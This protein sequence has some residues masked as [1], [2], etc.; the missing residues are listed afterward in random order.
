MNNKKKIMNVY[1]GERDG[2]GHLDRREQKILNYYFF[3][4]YFKSPK[5]HLPPTIVDCQTLR[6]INTLKVYFHSCKVIIL[7][8]TTTLIT[9]TTKLNLSTI[10]RGFFLKTQMVKIYAL[11]LESRAKIKN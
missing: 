10:K 3:K 7:F 4:K 11:H 5:W 8:I 2:G 9:I 1:R 6:K